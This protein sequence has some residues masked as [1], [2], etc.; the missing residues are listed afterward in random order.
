[1]ASSSSTT[2]TVAANTTA[3]VA[4][5][6]RGFMGDS[7]NVQFGVVNEGT[8]KRV[9]AF[10]RLHEKSSYL[11]EKK[12][13][14]PWICRLC[15]YENNPDSKTCSMCGGKYTDDDD[16]F[17]ERKKSAVVTKRRGSLLFNLSESIPEDNISKD[18]VTNNNKD[19]RP[20][21]LQ[22]EES[23]TLMS[24]AAP[25]R[26]LSDVSV[27]TPNLSV[28]SL[29]SLSVIENGGWT[30]PDCTFANTN[31]MHLTCG[32]CGQRKPPNIEKTPTNFTSSLAEFLTISMRNLNVTHDDDDSDNES[33]ASSFVDTQLQAYQ[34]FENT[35][36]F[37]RRSS[38]VA[39]EHVASLLSAT[40]KT[41]GVLS[42]SDTTK[43]RAILNEGALTLK[44]LEDQYYEEDREYDAMIQHQLAREIEISIQNNGQS[45]RDAMARDNLPGVRRI[46]PAV[47]EW[48]GQQGMLD[49]WKLQLRERFGE[50]QQLKNSQ[51]ETLK[52]I[53]R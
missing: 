10:C 19:K 48:H 45:P 43:L 41:E 21:L 23:L 8:S 42:E 35:A 34:K 3:A 5:R 30:C 6:P 27:D 11:E 44:A 47:L 7:F 33:D 31:P 15:K 50:I 4:A 51:E 2:T 29:A 40:P 32:V 16:N 39:R 13:K 24:L 20:T 53:L 49:D 28:T 46:S 52:L 25:V 17:D 37:K 38:M 36:K 1:M 12:V 18:N 26:N 9:L 14:G 22:R